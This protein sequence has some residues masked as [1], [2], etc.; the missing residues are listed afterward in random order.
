MPA[1]LQQTLTADYI[2]QIVAPAVLYT[3]SALDIQ[4]SNVQFRDSYSPNNIR[5]IAISP[6][7][8]IVYYH[9]PVGGRP[10]QIKYYSS[11]I[12]M[13]CE[14]MKGYK[15][16]INLIKT[17][18]VCSSIEEI[19]FITAG[20]DGSYLT[21]SEQWHSG[22]KALEDFKRLRDIVVYN[23]TLQQYMSE[24]KERFSDGL[25]LADTTYVHKDDWY[26]SYGYRPKF[27]AVD[28][29]LKKRFDKQI[30]LYRTEAKD[31]DK[32]KKKDEHVASLLKDFS[33]VYHRYTAMYKCY[34]KLRKIQDTVGVRCIAENTNRIVRA[35]IEE[36]FNFRLYKFKDYEKFSILKATF[37]LEASSDKE[38]LEQNIETLRKAGV[39]LYNAMLDGL[40]K[41]I[42]QG[43]DIGLAENY[44]KAIMI[45]ITKEYHGTENLNWGEPLKECTIQKALCNICADICK[46]TLAEAPDANCVQ[47]YK[48]EFWQEILGSQP[49]AT[50]E[51]GLSEAEANEIINACKNTPDYGYSQAE[52]DETKRALLS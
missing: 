38:A 14:F 27:Y 48:Y 12:L 26:K 9:V 1:K 2:R 21:S 19:V 49:S 20:T 28:E 39:T 17:P 51:D 3:K 25:S 10:Y 18:Y 5:K 15:P 29:Q 37:T 7:G 23:G 41:T 30:A 50:K 36:T 43:K 8:T 4:R 46:L 11:S 32:N 40:A 13:Q 45:G 16:I 6:E 33:K 31:A 44:N 22:D 52:L 42:A 24:D 35:S 34:K 47:Y